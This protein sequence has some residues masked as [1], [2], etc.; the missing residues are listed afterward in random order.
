M[1]R[2]MSPEREKEYAELHAYID[3]YATNV[4]GIDSASPSHPTNAGKEIVEKF[5]KS[6]ALDGLRQAANDTIEM[7]SNQPEEVVAKLDAALKAAGL[8]TISEVRR[9]YSATYKRILRR[10]MIR[11]DIEY[12]IIKGVAV[13]QAIPISQSERHALEEMLF[14]YKSGG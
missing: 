4:W 8:L 13:D 14:A 7:V 6:K 3:F 5:G 10:G 1:P 2:P 9:R 11:T 12:Y